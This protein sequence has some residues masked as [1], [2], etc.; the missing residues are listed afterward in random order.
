[1]EYS[2]AW[3]VLQNI[4][5]WVLTYLL[6]GKT[7][8]IFRST[9]LDK[10]TKNEILSMKLGGNAEAKKFFT[11]NGWSDFTNNRV[12]RNNYIRLPKSTHQRLL[13]Y[14]RLN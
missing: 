12:P 14:T 5:I 11:Q 13:S 8:F 6:P 9:V 2:Y 7:D 4:E 3:I 1:M 10:W